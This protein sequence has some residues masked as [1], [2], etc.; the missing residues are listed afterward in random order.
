MGMNII[1]SRTVLFCVQIY[2]TWIQFWQDGATDQ[3]D[4]R[5]IYLLKEQFGNKIISR[6]GKVN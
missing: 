4:I 6:N 3:A 5:T 1:T 2:M